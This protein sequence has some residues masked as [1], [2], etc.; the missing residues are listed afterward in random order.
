MDHWPVITSGAEPEQNR[1]LLCRTR[2]ESSALS[3]APCWSHTVNLKAYCPASRP[4]TVATAWSA[5]SSF[6]PVG[7]LRRK[8][9]ANIRRAVQKHGWVESPDGVPA[10]AGDATVVGAAAAVEQ[11]AVHWEKQP[12]VWT[13]NG[14]RAPV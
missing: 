6:D 5:P 9:S 13:H 11:Q 3:V 2:T 10:V 12:P 4:V 14:H 1:R 8:P 7:P